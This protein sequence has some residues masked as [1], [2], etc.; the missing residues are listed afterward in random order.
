MSI[1]AFLFG[2]LIALTIGSFTHLVTGGNLKNLFVMMLFSLIGFWIGNIVGGR[3]NMTILR[4]GDINLVA[5]V[6]GAII[7]AIIG[8]WFSQENPDALS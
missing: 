1:P 2:S 5:S 6:V 4:L 8:R 3:L 7:F